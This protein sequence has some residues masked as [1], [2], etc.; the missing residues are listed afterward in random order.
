MYIV[1]SAVQLISHVLLSIF[2]DIG[3]DF[4]ALNLEFSMGLLGNWQIPLG[5][6]GVACIALF[7][8]YKQDN[9]LGLAFG[10]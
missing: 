8:V 9:Q 5:L 1:S 7:T 3:L 4:V 10:L 6:G 2:K